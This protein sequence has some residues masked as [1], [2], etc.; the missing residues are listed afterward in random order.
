MSSIID[1]KVLNDLTENYQIDVIKDI[2]LGRS[3]R[4]LFYADISKPKSVI[5]KPIHGNVDILGFNKDETIELNQLFDMI[6]LDNNYAHVSG[7]KEYQS[8][9]RNLLF[10]FDEETD[11]TFPI[12]KNGRK[13]WLRV[14]SMPIK[15]NVVAFYIGN[16]TSFLTSEEQLFDKTHRDS[17]TQLFNK[18]TLD[19]HYGSRY[20]W[21]NFHVLYFD[22][23]NFKKIND[24]YGHHV[25]NECLQKFAYIL[26]SYAT[27]Y[28]HFY[29]IGGD[30]FIGLLF[31]EEH[32]IKDIAED[33][34]ERTRK[35]ELNH[36][37]LK[38]TTSLGIIKATIREDVIRK[39][40]DLLYEVK[41]SGKDHYKYAYET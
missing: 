41:T 33:I 25:G 11:V 8:Y 38:I 1:Q 34:L 14:L 10:R 35:I 29:R 15:N 13:I 36:A 32:E 20:L 39:A 9:V 24:S 12:L 40:D 23:D 7:K 18:Y 27:E 2:L 5:L 21:E 6:T 17:L 30:E 3:D 16:V 31:N 19:F 28:N 4:V 26:I 22:L 37:K